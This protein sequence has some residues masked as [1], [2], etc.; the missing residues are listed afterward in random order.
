MNNLTCSE[1]GESLIGQ[2]HWHSVVPSEGY[3]VRDVCCQCSKVLGYS[4]GVKES[5]PW[6]PILRAETQKS[7][8]RLA[9]S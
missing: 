2:R 8:R 7:G 4:C 5:K 3:P 6:A 1:C 9:I